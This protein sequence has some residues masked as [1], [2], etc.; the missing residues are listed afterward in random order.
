MVGQTESFDLYHP[1]RLGKNCRLTRS[2][3]NRLLIISVLKRFTLIMLS[4]AIVSYGRDSNK[5]S[6]MI[7][8]I[9]L[10]LIRVNPGSFTMGSPGSKTLRDKAEG[11]QTRV[12]ITRRFWL[13]KT[14]FTQANTKRSWAPILVD[15]K[16]SV[17]MRPSRKRLGMIPYNFASSSP[18]GNAQQSGFPKDTNTR[19]QPKPNGITP[20]EL[21]PKRHTPAFH[22]QWDGPT[23]TARKPRT[24]SLSYSP[25]TRGSKIC[26]ATY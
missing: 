2:C 23:T 20:A 24:Q 22:L 13:G 3:S 1:T 5:R 18:N 21:E 26:L 6:M 8:D 11:P 9:G 17:P 12:R 25:T 15:S 14:E 19:Y 7:P 16:Q 4:I 10:E